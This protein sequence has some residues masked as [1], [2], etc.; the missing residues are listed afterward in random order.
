MPDFTEQTVTQEAL[1]KL[2]AT[3]DPRLREIVQSLT[4]HLHAFVREVRLTEAE[5][6]EAIRFLT[7]T[8]KKCEGPRQEFILLSDT[9]GVSMLVDAINHPRSG[10]ATETTVIGPFYRDGAPEYD[11]GESIARG[12][13]GETT[14]VSGRVHDADGTPIAGAVIDVWQAA[15]TG[16]YEGQDPEM[17][18][19]AMRGRFRSDAAGRYEFRTVKP[20]SYPIPMDGPVGRLMEAVARQPY[21]PAHVH[22][23]VSAPGYET[24]CTHFFV[25]GDPYLDSDPV[26][27][28]KTSLV[29][30]FVRHDDLAEAVA[31][32]TTPPFYTVDFDFGLQRA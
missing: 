32:K 25:K 11:A 14:I 29:A 26:F 24:L 1:A 6:F 3:P 20:A 28:A 31:R 22:A 12:L 21:R 7:E 2:E 27:A 13:P 30:D 4:R 9:L 16:L 10:R 19:F 8:G 17:P 5:W 23:I 18:D 15:P